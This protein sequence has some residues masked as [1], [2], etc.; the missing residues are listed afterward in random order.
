V[1]QCESS[2]VSKSV[3][4]LSKALREPHA[5]AAPP[6]LVPLSGR[7][8]VTLPCRKAEQSSPFRSYSAIAVSTRAAA[9]RPEREPVHP[10]PR[11]KD[12]IGV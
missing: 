5:R 4:F 11:S 8:G 1:G 6:E 3:A 10:R 2:G 7:S 12:E 9:P